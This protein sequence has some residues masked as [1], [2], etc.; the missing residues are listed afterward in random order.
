MIDPADIQE[1]LNN[2][3]F[4]AF[5]ILMSD[6]NFYEVVDP[7]MVVAMENLL[8]IALPKTRWKF[9]SYQ[10]MTAIESRDVAA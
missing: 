8:F 2:D 7:D 1:L 6:G 5:R 10:N 3:R 4:H 9:L